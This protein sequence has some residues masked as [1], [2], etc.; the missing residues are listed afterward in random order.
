MTD[1]PAYAPFPSFSEWSGDVE[2]SAVDRAAAALHDAKAAAGESALARAVEIAT[3][4]AAVDTGAIEGL[5]ET[6]RGFT[7]TIAT[8]AAAWQTALKLRGEAVAR[9]IEDALAG[10]DFVLDAVTT[11]TPITQSWI[12]TLHEVLC[13]SQAT[14]RVYTAHGPADHALPKGAYKTMPNSPISVDTGLLHAY[15]PVGDTSAEMARLVDELASE[16]FTSAH[17]VEQAAY[18][19]YAFVCVHPF[20]DGNGRVAR[21]LASVFLYR[22]P[23]VPLVVFADQKDLYLDAL[24]AGD[25]GDSRPFTRFIAER[26]VDAVELVRLHL[27][28][29][30][31]S[32]SA[33]RH[34]AA[35]ELSIAM[36]LATGESPAGESA[37]AGS[38]LVDA[39]RA[40]DRLVTLASEELRSAIQA[41]TLPAGVA[42]HLDVSTVHGAPP[43]PAASPLDVP[44]INLA[45]TT[46]VPRP[47]EASRSV[48]VWWLGESDVALGGTRVPLRLRVA[49]LIP[50]LTESARVRTA[51][52]AT[53]EA[54][55][56]VRD[57][58]D[59]V[60]RA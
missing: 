34:S 59:A 9:S 6:N 35:A 38:N 40:A 8:Q 16:P 48:S 25:A 24:E 49:D 39:A 44:G 31:E 47:A 51:A 15:A 27:G 55:S 18:A 57:L 28:D 58:T 50:T 45:L 21:A 42:V 10:Y 1:S 32:S 3:R 7:R 30:L 13:R 12:R 33:E 14:Y 11:R 20:A 56:L 36:D 19:H 26:A 5:Y 37:A 41:M 54:E 53:A 52:W 4:Y 43:G 17:P 2:L 60:R 23:G 29:G 22:Q 46:R